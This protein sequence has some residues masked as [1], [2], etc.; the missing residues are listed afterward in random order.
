[1][2]EL[3]TNKALTIAS[4]NAVSGIARQGGTLR[5]LSGRLWITVEGVSHDYWLFAGD[6]F[7]LTP[8]ALTVMEADGANSRVELA[9]GRGAKAWPGLARRLAFLA[10]RFRRSR[11]AAAAL[12]CNASA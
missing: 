1:M 7:S 11:N 3:F 5:V 2:R 8:G 10:Q 9:T 4:G 12:P 6:T